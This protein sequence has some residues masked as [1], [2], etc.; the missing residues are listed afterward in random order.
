MPTG[1]QRSRTKRRKVVRTPGGNLVTHY[2]SRNHKK[3]VCQR[4][5]KPLHGIPRKST[6]NSKTKA[7]P[8]RPYGGVLCSSCSRQAIK[9]GVKNV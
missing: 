7:K 1:N 9:E 2:V 5:G 3:A 4:C 6:L 8:G